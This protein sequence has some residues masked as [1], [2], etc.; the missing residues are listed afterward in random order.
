M[1]EETTQEDQKQP[2]ERCKHEIFAEKLQNCVDNMGAHL[3][4][5]I[6]GDEFH[7]EENVPNVEFQYATVIHVLAE[8]LRRRCKDFYSI[9]APH[10]MGIFVT[11]ILRAAHADG[12]MDDPDA[13]PF[14]EEVECQLSQANR[15]EMLS[16]MNELCERLLEIRE[17]TRPDI[18]EKQEKRAKEEW[19]NLDTSKFPLKSTEYPK[20]P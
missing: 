3:D 19:D 5:L 4:N 18:T 1:T 12:Q 2:K 11:R 15:D 14:S 16:F 8:F 9:V 13:M 10:E 6:A 7:D 17:K 20:A